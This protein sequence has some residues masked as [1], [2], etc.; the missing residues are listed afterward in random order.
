MQGCLP[1]ARKRVDALATDLAAP[2]LALSSAE[3][4]WEGLVAQA[5]HEPRQMEGWTLPASPDLSLALFPGGALHVDREW[6]PTPG[7]LWGACHGGRPAPA[8]AE[9]LLPGV[10]LVMLVTLIIWL[11]STG[12][13]I[14]VACELRTRD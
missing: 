13:G 3:A 5:F 4:G 11:A 9:L 1:A 8:R 12:D 2:L 7:R 10:M 6:R 14:R